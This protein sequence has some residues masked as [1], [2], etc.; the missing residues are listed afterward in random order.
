MPNQ[1]KLYEGLNSIRR[2]TH[3]VLA[4]LFA[5]KFV[6]LYFLKHQLAVPEKGLD[7]TASQQGIMG[8]ANHNITENFK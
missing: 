4:Y 3:N 1:I 5:N 2:K 7:S 8:C 6:Q